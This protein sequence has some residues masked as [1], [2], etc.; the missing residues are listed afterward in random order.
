MAQQEKSEKPKKRGM[1]EQ[2]VTIYKFT[3]AEDKA[4]PWITGA[5]SPVPR[6]AFSAT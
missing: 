3:A 2:I 6:S 4:L 5:A 1:F